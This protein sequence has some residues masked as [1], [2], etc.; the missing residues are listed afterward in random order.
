ME[1]PRRLNSP[2]HS[3]QYLKRKCSKFRPAPTGVF[4]CLALHDHKYQRWSKKFLSIVIVLW[5]QIL[6]PHLS[7]KTKKAAMEFSSFPHSFILPSPKSEMSPATLGS[8]DEHIAFF[9]PL[10]RA[11]NWL[12]NLPILYFFH[13]HLAAICLSEWHAQAVRG[14]L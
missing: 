4:Y 9:F 8:R 7:L 12:W 13:S 14:F 6:L 1:H 2:L 11:L 3:P 10:Q 5:K